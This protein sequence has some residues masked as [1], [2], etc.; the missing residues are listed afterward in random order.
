MARTKHKRINFICQ[1]FFPLWDRK[2]EWAII[3]NTTR[4]CHG[5]CDEKQKKIYINHISDL[6]IIHEI[7]HAISEPGHG[8]KWQA[9]MSKAAKRAECL[10]LQSLACDIQEECEQYRLEGFKPT[11]QYIYERIE[12]TV[13][14]TKGK[15]DFNVII[16]NVGNEFGFT[17]SDML[18]KYKR[19]KHVYNRAIAG[20]KRCS[21]SAKVGH[22]ES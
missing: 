17:S 14:D 11:A 1:L 7:V 2:N 6:T 18:R 20:Y 13:I 22:I 10:G 19:L 9:R 21:P 15:V 16:E 4:D 12:S 5:Y 8:R 3:V